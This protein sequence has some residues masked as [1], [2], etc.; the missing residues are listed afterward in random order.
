[1]QLYLIVIFQMYRM[2]K[3]NKQ[4]KAAAA[5]RK[6]YDKQ[7]YQAN[8]DSI[9]KAS[10]QYYKANRESI[11]DA[12]KQYYKANRESRLNAMKQNHEANRESRLNAM[13]QYNHAKKKITESTRV[14]FSSIRYSSK[15]AMEPGEGVD[16]HFSRHQDCPEANTVLN[17]LTT[18]KNHFLGDPE[19]PED[20]KRLR[21]E[22]RAQFISPQKQRD[23]AEKFL[24]S[25]GRGCAWATSIGKKEFIEGKSR[26][27]P[28]LGC[29]CCGYRSSDDGYTKQSL[30]DL[31]CLKLDDNEVQQHLHRIENYNVELPV[32]DTGSTKL[33]HLWKAWSIWPQRN[34]KETDSSAS[35]YFLHPEFVEL[36][37]DDQTK[38]VNSRCSSEEDTHCAWLC[39]SCWKDVEKGEI[40]ASSLKAG[41]DYGSYHRVGLEPLTLFERHIISRVRHYAQVVKIESNSGRQ[42]EHTQCC[43]KGCC[44]VFDHDSPRVCIDLLTKAS[45][46]QDI[47]IHFVGPQGQHDTLL[48]KTRHIKPTHLFGRAYVVYQWMASL[49]VINHNYQFEPQLPPFEEFQATLNNAVDTLIDQSIK[50]FDDEAVRKTEI[51]RD[52]I[53]GI[54]ASSDRNVVNT[55]HIS[56]NLEG[57]ALNHSNIADDR[58]LP[59]RYSYVTSS[60]KTSND[61]QT[62]TTHDFLVGAAKTAGIDVESEREEYNQSKSTRSENPL[63]EFDEGEI[64][65]SGGWPDVFFLGNAKLGKKGSPSDTDVKHLLMQF[66][67]AAAD[68]RL[69]L[70]YLFDR[71]QRMSTISTM[72]AK[73]K[74]NPK[75]FEQ[76]TRTFMEKDF[77]TKLQNAVAN[78]EGKDGKY[79][80]NKLVPML[81][82]GGRN[83]VFGALERRSAAGEI[84]A[85]GRKHGAASNF[86]TVSVDDVH[87]PSVLR[88]GFRNCNN[89]NF[90]SH[91]PDSLLNAMELGN[92]FV[93]NSDGCIHG[94]DCIGHGEVH[95]PCSWSALTQKATENPV[96]VALHYKKVIHD[97]MTILVG[98]RPGTTSGN[99]NRS[100]KTEYRGWGEENM[101]VIVGTCA[102]FIGVTETTARGGLHF[103]VGECSA[104]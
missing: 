103:H 15:V 13:K 99:N 61:S 78:P 82:S 77:Q 67:S 18:Y 45:M 72:H 8:R 62:D 12:K 87:S 21:E 16:L 43:I 91:C 74:Q 9:I 55:Q 20:Y 100:L 104:Y 54:R 52:D 40:P 85:M 84:L 76:F 44:V 39:A 10:K 37:R 81:A 36:I 38:C 75:S 71:K 98:V 7:R 2:K 93:T 22:I 25:Q 41:I 30:S 64:A 34:L 17:H 86:L 3:S 51:A 79:V 101:G 80:L 97:L 95:I 73:I 28:I 88:M 66:T 24:L 11:L 60:N 56:A 65:L 70:F 102:A 32:D 31:H 63:N 35:Y 23:V 92:D 68:C 6:K 94:D 89:I 42:R 46:T 29:A 69:L 19:N 5:A 59:L 48:Q 49:K 26:D 47:C 4:H 27:V 1:M 90:P 14:N 58:E 50:T 57:L 96:S 83:T 33:F 53:A